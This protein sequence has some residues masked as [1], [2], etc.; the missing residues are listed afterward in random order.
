MPKVIHK[1]LHNGFC[2]TC[3]THGL[4]EHRENIGQYR[5]LV[6]GGFEVRL[7]CLV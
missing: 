1:T 6:C 4:I 7:V 2:Y 5:C 3:E